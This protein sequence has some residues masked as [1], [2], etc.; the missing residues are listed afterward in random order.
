MFSMQRYLSSLKN[1]FPNCGGLGGLYEAVSKHNTQ[2]ERKTEM[3]QLST[4][5]CSLR[6]PNSL[7]T[8]VQLSMFR[9]HQSFNIVGKLSFGC[10]SPVH[11]F[12]MNTVQQSIRWAMASFTHLGETLWRHLYQ[13]HLHIRPLNQ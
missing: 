1:L 12:Q 13:L 3:T 11:L 10:T 6:A 7:Y 5:H 4:Y 2:C 9:L 8:T